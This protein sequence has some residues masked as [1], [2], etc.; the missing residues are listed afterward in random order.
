MTNAI[1]YIRRSSDRQEESLDQQRAQ[2][3]AFSEQQGWTLVHVYVDDAISGSE[4]QRP[5]LSQLLHDAEHRH[6]VGVVLA[7]DRNRLARPKDAVDG[8]LLERQLIK[9]GKRIVYA[10]NGQEPDRSFA[11]GLISYVEHYQNGDYLRK[12]SRDTMRGL[13]ARVERGL[14]PGGPIPFGY[15]RLILSE[16]GEPKRIVRDGYDGGQVVLDPASGDVMEA[17]PKGRRHKKQ[18]HEAVTLTPSEP[19]RVRALQRVFADFA[20]GKPVRVIRDCLNE[21]GFRTSRGGMFTPQTI[22]PMLEN[23]AYIGQCVYNRRTLSKWHRVTDGRSVERQDEGVEKRP[24]S[25]WVVHPDAWP[26]LVD[27]ETFARVQIRRKESKT[28]HH[29]TTGTAVRAGYLLTGL[30][31]CGVCGGKLTGQTTTSG[32]GY[33]TRYYVCSTHHNGHKDRCP[34]RYTVP[35]SVVEEH[36]CGLIT[37]DLAKLRGDEKLH[38]YVSDKLRRVRGGDTDARDQLRRQVSDLD[39]KLAKLR[40]HLTAL[41][42]DTAADLG[43]YEQAKLLG[44]QRRDMEA[45]LKRIDPP[46]P[47]LPAVDELRLRAAAAFDHLQAVID[48]GTIEEKRELL[49][50]YVQTIKADPHSSTVQISL[51][52]AIFSRGIAGVGVDPNREFR[53]QCLCCKW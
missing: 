11:S 3:K 51:Y 36:V 46:A 14:W 42:P 39:Q 2:L 29:K 44:E 48:A 28:K 13:M 19:A 9:A 53:V 32:K 15:D 4:L 10:A 21:S 26:A 25:D 37:T 41:D 33:R 52:P 24:E 20:V 5:G 27:S 49:A 34:K 38:Q 50:A 40:D 8:L 17:L 22:F 1:G 35:A 18:D 45:E 43:L 6:D 23:P 30:V 16:D 7:W 31:H 12:L 47:D